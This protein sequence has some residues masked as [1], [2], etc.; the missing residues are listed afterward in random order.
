MTRRTNTSIIASPVLVGAV[1]VLIAITGILLAVKAN[2]GLPFVPTYSVSAELPGG[3]NL[4]KNAEVRIG[5]FRVGQV[6]RIR[7]KVLPS[8]NERAIAVIDMKLSKDVEPL[9]SSTQVLI[10]PRSALGLKY[11]ELVPGTGTDS[12]EAGATIPLSHATK[13]IELDEFFGMNDEPTRDNQRRVLKGYGTALAGR[14]QNINRAI[15]ELVPFMTHLEPVMRT[16]SAPDTRLGEFFRQSREF[17]AQIAPVA[18]TYADL[19]GNM[20]TTFEALSRHPDRLRGAIE[21][22]AP[23]FNTAIS[24]FRVQRPFLADSEKLFAEL[25]PVAREMERS[26][27]TVASAFEVG[28]PVMTRA[29]KL[30]GNT[31]RVLETLRTLVR[32]PSSLLALKD[33]TT[34]VKVLAPLVNYV[35]PYQTVCNYWNYYW[36]GISEH[37]SEPVRGGTIQRTVSK[38][39]NRAQ[40]N[41]VGDSQADRPVDV[42]S[43]HDPQENL[44]GQVVEALHGT[45]Y[46]PAIDAQGNADCQVGQYGY[47]D[48][49]LI[50][51]GRYKP[52]NDPSIGSPLDEAG[53]G[54]H[55]VTDSDLPG[56][57][58]PTFK[59]VKS[60]K[61]VP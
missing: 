42:P 46:G 17:S 56:L 18:D 28:A 1:T 38:T 30:Y 13:P 33:L 29:P 34:T 57:A 51:G 41:R 55:V 15:E 49:P 48:G 32:N 14:G 47:L 7:P 36:T 22:T 37:V 52:S 10:R 21:R 6:E 59:G 12:L 50:T 44:N 45:A 11:V 35:A 5:G 60:L 27:P 54:S 61:D 25:E 8:G 3:S 20:A 43:D 39:D 26:L 19:F 31:Q 16:L 2:Q 58:G 40:D 24:S 9:P 23:T 4:V 53:G